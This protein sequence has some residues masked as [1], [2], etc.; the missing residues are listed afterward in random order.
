[1]E[2]PLFFTL[3]VLLEFPES[4]TVELELPES[5][6]DPPVAV[7][8]LLPESFTDPP[9]AF[10]PE[11]VLLDLELPPAAEEFDVLELELLL[12]FVLPVGSVLG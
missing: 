12:V 1:L 9:V 4:F 11:A 2:L 6:T 7:E 5:L 3:D 8:E 10:P